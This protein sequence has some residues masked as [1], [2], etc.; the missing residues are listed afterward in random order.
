MDSVQP[1]Q[2]GPQKAVQDHL[3]INRFSELRCQ[4]RPEEY[5]L[6]HFEASHW[7]KCQ[8]IPEMPAVTEGNQIHFH[9]VLHIYNNLQHSDDHRRASVQ[10]RVRQLRN[11]RQ[12]IPA[13]A[14]Q[15]H[16]PQTQHQMLRPL[17]PKF[18]PF[19]RASNFR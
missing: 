7:R 11:A 14:V 13:P 6:L 4:P 5:F 2:Q 8:E 12:A 3:P 10:Q 16:P 9:Q 18:Q 1:A 15:L 17:Q 19:R